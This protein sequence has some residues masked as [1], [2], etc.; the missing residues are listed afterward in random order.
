MALVNTGK[1]QYTSEYVSPF[2]S[3]I[4]TWHDETSPGADGGPVWSSKCTCGDPD[5][6]PMYCWEIGTAVSDSRARAPPNCYP[7]SPCACAAT[8]L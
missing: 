1:L 2:G 6:G 3:A 4:A 7:A 8:V 5:D